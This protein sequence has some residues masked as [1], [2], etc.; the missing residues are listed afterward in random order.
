M[1]KKIF[2]YA[3]NQYDDTERDFI[4]SQEGKPKEEFEKNYEERFGEKPQE[5]DRE[6]ADEIDPDQN[7]HINIELK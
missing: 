5:V 4:K 3:S 2:G 1:F 7:R 6:K